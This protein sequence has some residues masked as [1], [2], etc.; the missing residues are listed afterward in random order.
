MRDGNELYVSRWHEDDNGYWE[1]TL[2]LDVNTGEVLRNLMG[3]VRR[4]PD[5]S[6][7]H[8]S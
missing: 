5:G 8:V 7:W 4:M 3:D 6:L 2:V 1:E